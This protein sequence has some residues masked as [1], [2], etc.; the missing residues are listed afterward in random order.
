MFCCLDLLRASG[1]GPSNPDKATLK[2]LSSGSSGKQTFNKLEGNG[3]GMTGVT[4][5]QAGTKHDDGASCST[6]ETRTVN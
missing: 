5:K 6:R 1:S 4:K 2:A 3:K